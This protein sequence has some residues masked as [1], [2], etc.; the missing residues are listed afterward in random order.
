MSESKSR[1]RKSVI[2]SI[3]AS[4]GR[5]NPWPAAYRRAMNEAYGMAKHRA[6]IMAFRLGGHVEIEG[7]S[8]IVTD[9]YSDEPLA[10]IEA[11]AH[12]PFGDLWLPTVTLSMTAR[13]KAMVRIGG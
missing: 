12:K 9:M 13:G 10:L 2:C 3:P 7:A 4:E 1:T 6:E 11:A 8:F 5:T